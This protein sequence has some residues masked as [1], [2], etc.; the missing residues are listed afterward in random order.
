LRG[1]QDAKARALGTRTEEA[2]RRFLSV[3][4][5][6]L[7]GLLRNAGAALILE[8]RSVFVSVDAIDITDRAIALID[9]QIGA[10]VQTAPQP[11]P[12]TPPDGQ[13]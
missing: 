10:G 11:N 12:E 6:V 3:A 8:R 2:Q 9:Q 4:Q 7:E 1:E 5:P 13:D